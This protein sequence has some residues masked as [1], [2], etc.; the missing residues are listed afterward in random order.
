MTV[1][2]EKEERKDV[3]RLKAI[4]S[5]KK[6][7]KLLRGK[8]ILRE[9]PGATPGFGCTAS[10]PLPSL[11][12]QRARHEFSVKGSAE[13]QGVTRNWQHTQTY[14]ELM[15]FNKSRRVKSSINYHYIQFHF[16]KN[17]YPTEYLHLPYFPHASRFGCLC[18]L[19]IG[20]SGLNPRRSGHF[21]AH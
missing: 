17:Q 10:W 3:K 8:R 16:L 9:M 6:S 2:M 14:T 18:Q 20:S 1:R 4:Q 13:S 11:T 15:I 12:C 5:T 21:Q 19:R 7:P